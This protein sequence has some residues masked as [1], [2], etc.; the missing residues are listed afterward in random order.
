MDCSSLL[1]NNKSNEWIDMRN[2]DIIN[3]R[4]KNNPVRKVRWTVCCQAYALPQMG[5]ERIP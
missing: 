1:W 5:T 3:K 4:K 2:D